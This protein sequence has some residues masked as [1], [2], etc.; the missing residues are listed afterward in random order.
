MHS[1]T[2]EYQVVKIIKNKKE[3][4]DVVLCPGF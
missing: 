4:G 3:N 2:P 1:P